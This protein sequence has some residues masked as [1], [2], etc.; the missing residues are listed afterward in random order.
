MLGKKVGMT[1]IFEEDGM[2]IPI[3]VLEVGPCLVQVVKVEE[4]DGYDSI[5]IGYGD[6]KEK[7]LKKPQREY[8]K[9]NGLKFKKF[10]REIRCAET[11]EVKV[12][13]EI[14]NKIFQK[15]DFLDIT[16]VS[17][18]KGFQGGVKRWG[19]KGGPKTHG[20]MSHR[21]PGSIGQSSYP[22]RVFKGMGMAGHMGNERVTIQNLEVIEVDIE[23][24]IIAVKGAVP[25]ANGTYIIVRYA[26]KKPVVPR[27][28]PEPEP[29]QAPEQQVKAPEKTPE[30]AAEKSPKQPGK[31]SEQQAEEKSE[32]ETG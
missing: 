15:G 13:D 24:N 30:K 7:R 4:K 19:W 1:Q 20:S 5:Q 8:L 17:K 28:E 21:A 32:K 22:S 25:G 18:G 27:Q 31:V 10:V 11:P 6:T 23:H 3:T 26:K 2:K 29:E 12:G 9:A 16:G 14:T